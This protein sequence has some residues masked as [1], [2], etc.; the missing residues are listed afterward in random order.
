MFWKIE[1][2]FNN[3]EHLSYVT[4]C[5][6][7]T[8]VKGPRSFAMKTQQQRKGEIGKKK[9]ERKKDGRETTQVK[10]GSIK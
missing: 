7:G 3:S 9:K 4:S 5:K 10:A 1:N 6:M 2:I 8:E